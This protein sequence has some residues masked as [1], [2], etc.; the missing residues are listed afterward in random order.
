MG[1]WLC[2]LHDGE[3]YHLEEGEFDRPVRRL[4]AGR[5][6]KGHNPNETRYG[7]VLAIEGI[8]V[9]LRA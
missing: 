6:D 7:A 1:W 8:G 4:D 3:E 5:A 9:T 2:W